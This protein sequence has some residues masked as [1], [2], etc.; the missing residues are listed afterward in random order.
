MRPL[1]LPRAL[2]STLRD[3]LASPDLRGP[4]LFAAIEAAGAGAGVEPFRACVA[5]FADAAPDEAEA[6][7]R[8]EAIEAHRD[9]LESRLLRDPGF[10]VA[11]AD[12]LPGRGG[13]LSGSGPSSPR[14]GRPEAHADLDA[15]FDAELSRVRRT[16]RPLTLALAAPIEPFEE[17]RWADLLAA[18][19]ESARDVD[20]IARCLPEGIAA[21]L[22]CTS[23][24]E[25][26]RAAARLAGVAERVSGTTWCVGVAC[27]PESGGEASDVAESARRALARARR[28]G[29]GAVRLASGERRL[30]GRRAPIGD[31][32]AR[33]GPK[34]RQAPADVE[35]LSLSGAL[36]RS[37]RP[38]VPGL[39]VELELGVDP[40]R[41]QRCAIP[42]TI[43]RAEAPPPGSRGAWRAALRF[44]PQSVPVPLLADLLAARR[45]RGET[46]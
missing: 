24:G 28:D 3:V 41:A 8:I 18:L 34:D 16:G 1:A 39:R 38:L 33:V 10:A 2:R 19:R 27:A 37:P 6:R 7:H 25:G 21:L 29:P 40:P 5:F 15:A 36:V 35:D 13:A 9:L 42:A 45:D 11:A 22:P 17:D 46:S 12:S 32:R 23:S 20:R 14:S 44:D 43:V 30:H 4:A 31:L 26:A